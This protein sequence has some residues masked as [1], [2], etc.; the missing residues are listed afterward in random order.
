MVL[1][2]IALRSIRATRLSLSR[3]RPRASGRGEPRRLRPPPVNPSG[4]I[5]GCT[6]SCRAARAVF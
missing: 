4:W 6:S 2:R 1:T 3:S 5:P